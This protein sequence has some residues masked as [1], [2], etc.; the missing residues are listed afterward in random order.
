MRWTRVMRA[1]AAVAAVVGMV[2]V[3]AYAVVAGQ[4]WTSHDS[5]AGAPVGVTVAR[6]DAD[7]GWVGE[8]V[9][10]DAQQTFDSF[11][12]T[13]PQRNA[14][15][16]IRSYVANRPMDLCMTDRGFPEWDWSLNRMYADPADPLSRSLWFAQPMARWRSHDL[17]ALRPFLFAEREMN[18]DQS[19]DLAAAVDACL[20]V[21]QSEVVDSSVAA[22]G[23]PGGRLTR[24]WQQMVRD[25]DHVHGPDETAYYT[26]MDEADVA[27]LDDRDLPIGEVGPAM[28]G[29]SPDDEAIPADVHDLEQWSH[30]EW[31]RFLMEEQQFFEQDWECRRKV[32][33]ENIDALGVAVDEFTEANALAIARARTRWQAIEDQARALGYSGESGSLEGLLGGESVA[34]DAANSAIAAQ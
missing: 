5:V 18:A 26:C 4:R 13:V 7:P 2:L 23:R 19:A 8:Q 16:V 3:L 34:S 24:A 12:G 29:A 6:W 20:G 31:Q 17:V 30:P 1:A 28:S 10:V 14:L 27:I 32:Y 25:F 33:A 9:R 22:P 21:V 11:A 15:N